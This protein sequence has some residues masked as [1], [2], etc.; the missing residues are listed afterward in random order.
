MCRHVSRQLWRQRL[1]RCWWWRCWCWCWCR[2][3][4]WCWCC[5]RCCHLCFSICRR[6]CWRC[7]SAHARRRLRRLPRARPAC[8]PCGLPSASSS[9]QRCRAGAARRRCCAAAWR[10]CARAA[11][12]APSPTRRR[13]HA[14][15]RSAA[16]G[17]ECVRAE[18]ERCTV[19][20]RAAGRAGA[21]MPHSRR[22]FAVSLPSAD[23]PSR[24]SPPSVCCELR[25][26]NNVGAM[27]GPAY[28]TATVA[29]VREGQR[30]RRLA[31]A[32]QLI[33]GACSR[34]AGKPKLEI[35]VMGRS[36]MKC[37]AWRY[38]A[39]AG[40]RVCDALRG[41]PL[42]QPLLGRWLDEV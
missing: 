37:H 6:C 1:H 30:A 7:C 19:P 2:C 15:R 17:P 16:A 5:C 3:W 14:P 11:R 10:H 21:S 24:P 18:H 23:R 32:L 38:V 39:G 8:R 36:C 27:H 9:L 22:P 13:C 41:C 28:L 40:S 12:A 20:L 4:C 34:V 26:C 31:G 29:I 25:C 42:V 33:H 35:S